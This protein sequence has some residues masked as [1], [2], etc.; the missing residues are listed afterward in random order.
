MRRKSNDWILVGL[1]I[2]GLTIFL[3]ITNPN[4]NLTSQCILSGCQPSVNIAVGKYVR[5]RPLD[6]Q[7][8]NC[9]SA[10]WVLPG[11][12]P[13]EILGQ[14]RQLKPTV[15]ERYTSGPIDSSYNLPGGINVVTFLDQSEQACSCTIWP[16]V[17]LNPS[18]NGIQALESVAENLL[19][20][21]VSPQFKILAID[22]WSSSAPSYTK[23]QLSS[24]F[25]T[26]KAQ[27]WKGF[28]VNECGGYVDS[29]GYA[30]FGDVCI[31]GDFT[32]PV[33]SLP[34]NMQALAYFD[35]PNVICSFISSRSVSQ[36]FQDWTQL[37]KNQ[38]THH[39]Q[40][41]YMVVQP[42][43]K[44]YC[45]TSDNPNGIYDSNIIS[46]NGQ[47]QVQLF[48]NLMAKYN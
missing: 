5:I 4:L 14:L 38:A 12:S 34:S 30:E 42:L 19:D 16:R 21:R 39:F 15:L 6:T 13:E 29:Y 22:L 26:L 40:V 18:P 28:D 17:Q 23:A 41:V 45:N 10:C 8:T 27:G 7:Y 48:Q 9:N 43:P 47:T 25:D 11:Y 35:F 46:Y 20:L 33:Q 1:V 37:A 3:I 44:G 24:M 32:T 31:G 2:M 36:Q